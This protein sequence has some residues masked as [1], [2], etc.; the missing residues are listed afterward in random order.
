MGSPQE[1]HTRTGLSSG[2]GGHSMPLTTQPTTH[3]PR[4]LSVMKHT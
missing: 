1:G 2:T 3:P 4:P